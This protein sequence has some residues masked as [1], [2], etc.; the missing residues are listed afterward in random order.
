MK[1]LT[2]SQENYLEW[3]YRLAE[4]GPVHVRRLAEKVGVKLPSASR[5][6]AGLVAKGLVEHEKYG[7]VSLT[8]EGE[9]VGKEIVRRDDC[10]TQFLVEILAMKPCDAD[11]VVHRMEHVIDG[12]VLNRVEILVDFALSSP[13]WVRRLR[14]R[15]QAQSMSGFGKAGYQVGEARVHG[16]ATQEKGRG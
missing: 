1:K 13:A 7:A 14:H 9:S 4:E 16:G 8:A 3:I 10:L 15:M 6:I 11:P 5:A 2:A 12:E